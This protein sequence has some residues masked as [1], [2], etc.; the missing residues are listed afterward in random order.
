MVTKK[1]FDG[2]LW[3]RTDEDA[4]FSNQGKTSAFEAFMST[5]YRR[6]V[7]QEN[8]ERMQAIGQGMQ[9]AGAAL[10]SIGR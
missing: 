2:A 5:R 8:R 7:A 4:S 9:N 1:T 10:S 6:E 3:L